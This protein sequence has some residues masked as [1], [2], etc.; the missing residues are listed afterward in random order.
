MKSVVKMMR[1][2][3]IRLKM[4][5][6]EGRRQLAAIRDELKTNPAYRLSFWAS[7]FPVLIVL[8]A[9]FVILPLFSDPWNDFKNESEGQSIPPALLAD[10]MTEVS[11]QNL[12]ILSK[13]DSLY[14]IVD[15]QD[16]LVSL[17]IRG[18]PVRDCPVTRIRFSQAFRY[19]F[20]NGALLQWLSEPFSSQRIWSTIPKSILHVKTAPRDT[21][22]AQKKYREPKPPVENTDVF[23]T[24]C[25]DKNLELDIFQN[26]RRGL[27]G[28]VKGSLVRTHFLLNRLCTE[29]KRLFS[30]HFPRHNLWIRIEI[31][32]DDA[33]AI[34]RAL[35][36]R[37]KLAIRFS[38][39]NKPEE[40]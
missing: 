38:D 22:E 28:I 24:M 15:L 18:V 16:S 31:S 32:R 12:L 11:L 29:T 30:G 13:S 8:I 34:Y 3:G 2:M 9:L 10:K 26:T 7:F 37:P 36:D 4:W 27:S 23:L 14:L 5:I 20:E 40:E 19:G 35:P 33:R 25:F 17:C 21:L 6:T 39:F 1:R